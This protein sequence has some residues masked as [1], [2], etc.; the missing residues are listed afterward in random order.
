MKK[1]FLFATLIFTTAFLFSQSPLPVGKSQF[2][3]GVGLSD[4]G[5]PVYFGIDHSVHK[6][7]TIGGEFS[8]RSYHENWHDSKYR[9][10]IMGF[11]GNGNYHFNTILHIPTNW[12]FY[13]G[14]NIGFFVWTSPEEYDGH[15]N[16]GLG[17][18]AQVGGRYYFTDR[19][20]INLELGGGN[21]L[22]GGKFGFTFKL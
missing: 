14:P 13:A 20:G 3:V 15:N 8:F 1:L 11:L 16:S 9:H 19:V 5:I 4:W 7:I 2:N 17:L 21:A 12:D 6:D 22:S 18:G 10:N